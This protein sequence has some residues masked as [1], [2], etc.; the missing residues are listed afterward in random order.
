MVD[1]PGS[2]FRDYNLS[3]MHQDPVA[4][5]TSSTSPFQGIP[6][7]A[8][9]AASRSCGGLA[10]PGLRCLLSLRLRRLWWAQGA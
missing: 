6:E 1:T 5:Q 4:S 3:W 8:G 10:G 2:G 9:E 7:L